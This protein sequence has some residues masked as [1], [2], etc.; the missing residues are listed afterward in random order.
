MNEKLVE[1][2][3]SLLLPGAT[4]PSLGKRKRDDPDYFKAAGRDSLALSDA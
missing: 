1:L 4:L 2:R 3:S